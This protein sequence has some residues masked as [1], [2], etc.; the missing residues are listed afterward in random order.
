MHDLQENQKLPEDSVLRHCGGRVA[1]ISNSNPATHRI[2]NNQHTFCALVLV[3][4]SNR[5]EPVENLQLVGNVFA[6]LQT[7]D[8]LQ[9]VLRFSN[10]SSGITMQAWHVSMFQFLKIF[11][12]WLCQTCSG[13]QLWF[14]GSFHKR[15]LRSWKSKLSIL[16]LFPRLS[17]GRCFIHGICMTMLAFRCNA[18]TF[19]WINTLLTPA[20]NGAKTCQTSA[21]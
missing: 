17:T 7:F 13:F 15:T 16:L 11:S 5:I 19:S 8:D 18:V 3:F 21:S 10:P 4:V 9:C 2:R 20:A 14:S 6:T 12:Y 1:A